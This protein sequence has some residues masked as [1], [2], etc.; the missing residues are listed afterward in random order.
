MKYAKIVK[1]FTK[2]C[3]KVLPIGSVYGKIPTTL[4]HKA[5]YVDKS[6]NKHKHASY[7]LVD[8]TYYIPPTYQTPQNGALWFYWFDSEHDK[9]VESNTKYIKGY[10]IIYDVAMPLI[11]NNW[12]DV[13]PVTQDRHTWRA[14]AQE[15]KAS[16]GDSIFRASGSYVLSSRIMTDD[17]NARRR[18]FVTH[19]NFA[20]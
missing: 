3:G 19:T 18:S 17:I 14:P 11:R 6:G 2:L 1:N 7:K 16:Q 4:Y 12:I 10:Q 15:K 5:G 9:W 13:D 20:R 8:V